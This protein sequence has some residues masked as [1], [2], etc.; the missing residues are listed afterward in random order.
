M[1]PRETG[2]F[3]GKRAW[4]LAFATAIAGG[5]VAL[6]L[7]ATAQAG[8]DG[9]E[10]RSVPGHRVAHQVAPAGFV[11]VAKNRPVGNDEDGKRK[12]CDEDSKKKC[13]KECPP[14]PPGPPG[15][16]AGIDTAFQGNNKFVGYAQGNGPTF[17]RDPRTAS[18]WH[19]VSTLPGYPGN[20]TDVSLAV[21]GNNLHVTVLSS[22]GL[23]RQTTCTV[24]PTPGTGGNPAWP[25]NCSSFQELTPPL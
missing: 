1:I 14:G 8:T 21:M 9:T 20:A 22:T 13:C 11:A 15:R 6:S 7:P 16:S 5:V 19:D 17:V 10:V 4:T 23:I 25:G 18:P 3:I 2:P 12:C 24:N